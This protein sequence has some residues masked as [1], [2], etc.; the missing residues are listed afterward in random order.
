MNNKNDDEQQKFSSK[1]AE[2]RTIT[3]SAKHIGAY[4]QGKPQT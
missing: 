1:G 2:K 3:K 4:N